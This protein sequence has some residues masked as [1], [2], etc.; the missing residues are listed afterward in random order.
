MKDS[1]IHYSNKELFIDGC[2][3]LTAKAKIECCLLDDD[4]VILLLDGEGF[5]NDRNIF[6]YNLN[7]ILKWQIEDPVRLHERNYYTSIYFNGDILQA[8]NKN[9]LEVTINKRSGE[10]LDK[11]LIK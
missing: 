4:L 3:F 9:G 11:E 6:C 2:L 1:V 8:Y 7:K 10:I 5:G